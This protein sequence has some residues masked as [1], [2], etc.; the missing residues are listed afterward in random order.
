MRKIEEHSV[1]KLFKLNQ[2]YAVTLPIEEIR[3]LGWQEK[4][5]V[6]VDRKGDTLVIKDWE[7]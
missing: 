5:K 1:R 6:V 3:R 7:K 4:Q 2:T